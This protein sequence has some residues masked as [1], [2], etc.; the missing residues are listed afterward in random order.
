M[1]VIT[2]AISAALRMTVLGLSVPL[3]GC[4]LWNDWFGR[5]QV[6]IVTELAQLP[7]CGEPAPDAPAQVHLFDSAMAVQQ[8]QERHGMAASTID[9]S[10]EGP[11][12]LVVLGAVTSQGNSL[13]VSRDAMLQAGARLVLSATIFSAPR[14][15]DETNPCVLLALPPRHY[16]R[17]E[18]YD[19]EGAL[20]ATTSTTTSTNEEQEP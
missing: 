12:A 7:T 10:V 13:L 20:R 5:E 8:W 14:A 4:A 17:I 3:A 11:F 19:Q 9:E 1:S 2:K 16:R 6:L 18:I 15:P